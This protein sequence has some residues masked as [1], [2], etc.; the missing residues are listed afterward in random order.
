M[1][2]YTLY[3]LYK[4]QRRKSGDTS[5]DWEDV[6]PSVYSYN[7]DGTMTPQI[8]E[9]NSTECG[10]GQTTEPMYKW[11]NM[12]IST[13]WICD[14]CGG[15]I[16]IPIYRWID[17]DTIC[18]GGTLYNYQKRQESYNDG[19]QW[20]DVLPPQYQIGSVI[21]TGSSQ[22][23]ESYKKLIFKS[24]SANESVQ[25]TSNPSYF[26]SIIINGEEQNLGGSDVTYNFGDTEPHEV[27]VKFI[28]NIDSLFLCFANCERLISIPS[29]LFDKCS[30]VENMSGC[31]SQCTSLSSI[32]AELFKPLTNVTNF[33][34]CFSNC[35]ALTALSSNL[36]NNCPNIIN[37]TVMSYLFQGCTSLTSIPS[38]LFDNCVLVADFNTLFS[39]CSSLKTIPSNLFANCENIT[40]LSYAFSECIAL[41]SQCPIDSDGNPIYNRTTITNHEDCF[42]NCTKM[43]D[44]S[45]IPYD[46]K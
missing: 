5:S 7:G 8:K 45:S 38:G 10:Y 17:F 22:C 2:E 42:K 29:D 30:T 28:S 34:N 44:F 32:P 6:V 9:E 26:E 33:S 20:V 27:L 24:E 41:I 4:K 13:N 16:L 40:N 15:T 43:V 3:Y 31:F 21:E 1:S 25:I 46:W 19:E 11:E 14:E 35:S 37:V 23:D 39:G 18:S 36:F 12:D